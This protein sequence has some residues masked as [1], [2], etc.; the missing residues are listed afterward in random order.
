MKAFERRPAWWR[1]FETL[2]SPT[3]FSP[4]A[5]YVLA[6]ALVG[7]A[8]AMR[9]WIAPPEAGLP[10]ITFFPAAALAAIVGGIGPGL[11]AVVLCAGLAAA[12][13]MPPTQEPNSR[14]RPTR[15]RPKTRGHQ[16]DNRWGPYL[17]TPL[18][19]PPP[20]PVS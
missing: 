16:R 2:V 17:W 14:S 3:T 18:D 15:Y 4:P 1:L 8:L 11:L 6:L 10:F 13:F 20:R 9:L 5:R 12:L 7:L 19:P